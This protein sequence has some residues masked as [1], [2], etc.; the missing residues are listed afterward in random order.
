ML[1]NNEGKVERPKEVQTSAAP[2][3]KYAQFMTGK[4][5]SIYGEPVQEKKEEKPESLSLFGSGFNMFRNNEKPAEKRPEPEV[6]QERT[7]EQV[8]QERPEPKTQERDYMG[9]QNSRISIDDDSIPP[10]LRKIR[11]R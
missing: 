7:Y 10:F 9:I 3:Q 6:Q 4:S 1:K 5:A 11:K 8:R 2:T